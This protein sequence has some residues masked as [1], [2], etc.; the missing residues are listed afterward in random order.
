MHHYCPVCRMWLPDTFEKC[1]VCKG[2]LRKRRTTMEKLFYAL[3]AA[4]IALLVAAVLFP[5]PMFQFIQAIDVEFIEIGNGSAALLAKLGLSNDSEAVAEWEG[6]LSA[7]ILENVDSAA[8]KRVVDTRTKN[9]DY[10]ERIDVLSNYVTASIRYK[11]NRNYTNV[12]DVLSKY[13]GDD[14]SHVI[15]LASMLNASGIRFRIDVVEDASK[16]GRGFH[17]RILVLVASPEE[18]VRRIV[19]NRIRKERSGLTGVKAK[20]WYVKEGE[21]RWYVID[22]TGQTMKRKNS[23]VDTSWIYLG[24][25]DQYYDDRSHYNFT[26]P[27]G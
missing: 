1:P 2:R 13:S 24:A 11:E 16:G 8:V 15:L 27:L 12:T 17:Y 19:I 23:M 26:L 20:V 9:K 21:L 18:D 14:R 7:P 6:N 22:T 4:A 3:L 5:G 25:S 10:L